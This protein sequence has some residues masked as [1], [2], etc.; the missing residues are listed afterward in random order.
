MLTEIGRVLTNHQ[1]VVQV[2]VVFLT[3]VEH[4][5]TNA[6][7]R[8]DSITYVTADALIAHEETRRKQKREI[9]KS[10]YKHFKWVRFI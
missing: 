2:D 3:Y 6:N 8:L 5:E 10:A 7:V 1:D 9:G 4:C